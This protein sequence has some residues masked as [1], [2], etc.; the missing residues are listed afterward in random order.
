MTAEPAIGWYGRQRDGDRH[1]RERSDSIMGP[2]KDI[3]LDAMHLLVS[4]F[5][6]ALTSDK[7]DILVDDLAFKRKVSLVH[8]GF[9]LLWS[10]W[11]EALAG[12]YQAAAD[13]WRSI[14]E[15]PDFITA[16]EINPRLADEMTDA[17]EIKIRTVRKT[18]QRAL[19]ESEPGSGTDLLRQQQ[20]LQK[21][22][23]PLSHVSVQSLGQYLPV[24]DV[25]PERRSIVRLGGV[26]SQ[27]TLR[28]VAIHLASAASALLTATLFGFQT[29][30]EIEDE[31][32]KATTNRLAAHGVVLRNEL[33]A[34]RE[35]TSRSAD[36]LYLAR[37][38]E[39]M[40]A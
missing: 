12:R 22:L 24:N 33:T 40:P 7:F 16:L 15:C 2:E 38:D 31:L 11:D 4:H 39:D 37:S 27:L 28:L 32:W 29:V 9:N 10:A 36:R 30:V 19:N 34:L 20:K 1:A 25:G 23:Q 6:A 3:F 13:H 18:I 8:Y 17:R 5:D 14:D 26:V 21:D 35:V